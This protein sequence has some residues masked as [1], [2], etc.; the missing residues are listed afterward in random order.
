MSY[1][2]KELLQKAK[3]GDMDSFEILIEGIK[4]KAFQ[5][6]LSYLKNEEDAKDALQDSLLKIYRS[7][8]HFNEKSQFSTWVYR[9]VV[10][11]CID[12]V[13][14]NKRRR[15]NVTELYA[16]PSE[17]GASE[18]A[19]EIPDEKYQPEQVFLRKEKRN[20][21]LEC[22]TMLSAPLREVVMLRDI[23][24]FTYGEIADILQVS[25]GTVK[26]RLNRG[27]MTLKELF[28]ETMEQK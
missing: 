11:T 18:I 1:L 10:N 19:M 7:L 15:N 14:K 23:Q 8:G 5:I 16:A 25:E 12:T 21:I 26:S 27:R 2:E 9:V 28:L 4:A 3:A 24:G 13:K 20:T 17:E 6:A 22:L